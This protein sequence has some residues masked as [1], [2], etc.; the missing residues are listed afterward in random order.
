MLTNP[1]DNPVWASLSGQHA[2]LARRAGDALW[3]DD[4]HTP[5]VAVDDVRAKVV[6]D[7][8]LRGRRYFVGVAPLDLPENWI[9][10]ETSRYHATPDTLQ[11]VR[12]LTCPDFEPVE[13]VSVLG[14]VDWNAMSSLTAKVYPEFFRRRTPE[15]GTYMGV[16]RDGELLAMAGERMALPGAVEISAVCTHPDHLGKG[17][18]GKVMRAL[19]NRHRAAGLVS[20]LHVSA[21]NDGATR[22]YEKLGFELRTVLRLTAV[23]IA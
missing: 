7:A 13:D 3:Y 21:G 19:I 9:R 5:F 4:D 22:L 20:F 8:A 18:A 15:L 10:L 17:L 11:F 1:M 14:P 16:I 6:D 12:P 2:G 23:D